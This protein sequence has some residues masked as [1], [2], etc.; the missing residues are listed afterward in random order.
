M[1]SNFTLMRCI[2][3]F[4]FPAIVAQDLPPEMRFSPD[5]RMLLMG[6]KPN[7]GLYDQSQIKSIYLEFSQPDFWEQMDSIYWTLTKAEIP[8]TM[9]VDGITYPGVGI[10]FKGQTSY[11][12]IPASQKKSFSVSLDYSIAGQDLM[13]FNSLNLNNNFE[14]PSFLREIFYETMIKK[15]IPAAKTSCI[16]LYINDENWGLYTNVQQLNRSFY[17]EWFSSSAG[18]NWR[19]YPK[20]GLLT[21]YGDGAGALNYLG[22]DS[23]SYQEEYALKSFKK[24]NPWEDLISACD[25]LNNTTLTNLPSVLPAKLDI[26]RTLWFLAS[27]ILFSDDDSYIRNGRM[28]YFA[29]WEKE[30]G[31]ITPLEY[32]GNAVMNPNNKT[33]SPFYHADSVNYPLMNRLFAIS[34][35]RQRYLAHFRT[36]MK[37]C[38]TSS[39]A[40]SII[41]DY[42]TQIDTIVQNDTK[43]LYSYIDFQNEVVELKDFINDRRVFLENHP[44]VAETAPLISNVA[45]YINNN[46]WQSPGPMENVTVRAGANSSHG[47]YRMLLFYSAS[48]SGNFTSIEMFDDGQHNDW[49]AG[50]GLYGAVIPG[51]AAGTIVRFYVESA[52]DN[53]SKSVSYDPP[54]AEHN[55]YCYIIYPAVS[56]DDSMVLNE[57][58]ADNNTTA[59]DNA[60]EFDDW[61]ELNNKSSAPVDISGYAITDNFRKQDKWKF[62]PGTIIPANGY[63]ILWADEDSSQG[64]YHTNFK[65]SANGE[66]LFLLDK[67]GNLVDSL[68]WQ[69]QVMDKGF[70]RL[71]DGS[72][73]FVIQE[74]TFGA[75][76]NSAGTVEQMSNNKFVSVIPNPGQGK[77]KIVVR[78][79]DLIGES[80]IL[81]SEILVFDARGEVVY[82]WLPLNEAGN[83]AILDLSYLAPGLYFVRIIDPSTISSAEK[84]TLVK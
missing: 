67:I 19:S 39:V 47:I 21:P 54:G 74:P 3:L 70:A 22:P 37:E 66:K 53:N 78:N 56:A 2:L 76:N 34:S 1:I 55:V 4:H 13:G 82:R 69:I 59:I 83:N 43:K 41:D 50:D 5:G 23:A 75:N 48:L 52:A 68:S 31:R 7:M 63:H 51:K 33:W 64:I 26:D 10:R 8:A 65:L 80:K 57:I 6:D 81:N 72:G 12:Q 32:D 15:H 38:F 79:N 42:K 84:I 17:K 58:M 20:S 49:N 9:V 40:D 73:N 14:D 28:D 44:E 24:T 29:Y 46:P 45:W 25:A 11:Q 77:F 71:P 35:Y 36:L 61:I 30:T 16:K 18:S 60:G 62:P 27:E